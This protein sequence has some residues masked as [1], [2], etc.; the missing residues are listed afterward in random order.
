MHRRTHAHATHARLRHLTRVAL[1][2][3][4]PQLLAAEPEITSHF[5]FTISDTKT[6]GGASADFGV[7]LNR[8][9][10]VAIINTTTNDL[11]GTEVLANISSADAFSAAPLAPYLQQVVSGGETPYVKSEAPPEKLAGPG[12]VHTREAKIA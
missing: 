11:F 12:E 6:M 10:S 1:P 9:F 3:S 8:D 7:D 5:A 4:R 2:V